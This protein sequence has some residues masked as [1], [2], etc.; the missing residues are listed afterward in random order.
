LCVTP[1]RIRTLALNALGIYPSATGGGK[2]DLGQ[3]T[4]S[5]PHDHFRM[6]WN[7]VASAPFD[8]DLELAVIDYDGPHGLVF[9]CRRILDGWLNAET[10]MRI[11]VRP[12][13]WREWQGGA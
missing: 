13:H 9:P 8:R 4:N 12:T 3:G 1:Q 2:L 11:D 5:G 7:P 6:E 10:T